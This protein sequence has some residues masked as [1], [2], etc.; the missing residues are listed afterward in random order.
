MSTEYKE[1]A[2]IAKNDQYYPVIENGT[3]LDEKVANPTKNLP[4]LEEFQRLC[5]KS[6]E[7]TKQYNQLSSEL[8]KAISE[9]KYTPRASNKNLIQLNMN[10]GNQ[11][12][13]NIN[14]LAN[15]MKYYSQVAKDMNEKGVIDMEVGIFSHPYSESKNGE[16]R[17]N[18][19]N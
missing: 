14:N 9:I 13:V 11:V 4:I 3:V 1:I 19:N 8:Q 18:R 17:A 5:K 10:D 6:K 7:L 16:W 12:I 2:L 15:Q